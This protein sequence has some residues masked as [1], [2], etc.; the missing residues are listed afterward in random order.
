MRYEVRNVQNWFGTPVM[1]GTYAG[2]TITIPMGGV[3]PPAAVGGS[4]HAPPR[5]GP[6]FDVFI[7]RSVK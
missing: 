3:A 1:S 2:G 4:P 7:V 6:D 5:T